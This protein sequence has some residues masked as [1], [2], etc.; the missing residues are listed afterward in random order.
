MS[1]IALGRA[2]RTRAAENAPA[3]ARTPGTAFSPPP[4][5]A[6]SRGPAV[7]DGRRARTAARGLR[8]ASSAPAAAPAAS[9]RA[10]SSSTA[11]QRAS[12]STG[13]REGCA[14]ASRRARAP[15][16]R[17]RAIQEREEAPRRVE[18]SEDSKSSSVA[19]AA[20]S[21]PIRS[22][23]RQGCRRADVLEAARAASRARTRAPRP[24]RAGRRGEG[25]RRACSAFAAS[26][27]H[28]ACAPASTAAG[29][30]GAAS[31]SGRRISRGRNSA[32][33]SATRAS[34]TVAR[35]EAAR[36]EVEERDA[37][38]GLRPG[39]AA[40]R[41]EGASGN[42]RLGIED[43]A[44]RDDPG[45]VAA[46]EALRAPRA[47][48]TWSQMATLR[49]AATS[50]AT[51]WST[52]WCGT[53]HIGA[54]MSESRWRA[55]SAMPRSGAASLGVVEEHLVEVAHPIEE[56]RVRHA[57]LHLEVLPEHRGHARRRRGSRGA[58]I[59]SGAA[60]AASAHDDDSRHRHREPAAGGGA[61]V[62]SG[63]ALRGAAARTTGAPPRSC[64]PR[65]RGC[66]RAPDV[67][68][69]DCD[70]HRRLRGARLVHG[71]PR[72]PRDGVGARPRGRHAGRDRLDARGDRRGV[73][74]ARRAARV[75]AAL[76]AGRGDVVAGALRPLG[77]RARSIAAPALMRVRR[78]RRRVR[79]GGR[80]ASSRCRAACSARRASR[81]PRRPR[82]ARWPLAGRPGAPRAPDAAS[83]A[84][85]LAAERRGGEAWRC[86]SRASRAYR[87]ASARP[88]RPRRDRAHRVRVLP[89][90]LEAR[91]LRERARRAAPL[92][93][94]SSAATTATA[95]RVGGYL[96]AVSLY[97]EFHINKIATDLRLRH[98]G[99]GRH[100]P[101]GRARAGP[102]DRARR[103][104]RSRSASP[105]RAA[106]AVLPVL[107]FR[108]GL[109]PPRLLPGR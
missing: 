79:G 83:R 13:S 12:S 105:T 25:R 63:R 17:A 49:P 32:R 23:K 109:P 37:P 47:S 54:S 67:T 72:R 31:P 82:S 48:S 6:T 107:R 34:G 89:R 26:S 59:L 45:D 92:R 64:F 71:T 46:D 9:R 24:P 10:T 28:A 108:R 44:R 60:F 100:P 21:S 4:S 40:A 8:R 20:A 15:E 3:A 11:S 22:P 39:R 18:P 87:L 106:R 84:D 70:A 5:A 91:V 102:L 68:L 61:L 88:V 101:R 99:Y 33:A 65:S 30:R 81:R 85:L 86:V 27:H 52:L 95:P 42:E 51:W 96:F 41:Y 103:P 73:A 90:P 7:P 76:D 55:V 78:P 16:R 43:R 14:S 62:A 75:V 29:E 35:V 2:R 94:G 58:S 57:A 69:A 36:R 1:G 56:D 97:E 74:R 38:L 93:C 66:S 50:W 98:Q 19:I 53:P 104:S 77:E 80:S